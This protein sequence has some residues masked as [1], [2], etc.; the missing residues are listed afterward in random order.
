MQIHHQKNPLDFTFLNTHQ[1]SQTMAS[2][3]LK[4]LM[5]VVN[6]NIYSNMKKEGKYIQTRD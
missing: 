1:N 6:A 3:T 4:M 2:A 5:F